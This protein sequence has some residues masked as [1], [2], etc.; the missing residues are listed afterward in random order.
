[1]TFRVN[2]Q[3]VCVDSKVGHEQ[4]IEIQEGEVYTVAWIGM[5]SHYVHGEY[6]GV[7]LAGIDRK[8]CPHFGYDN[9]PFA[10][11]RFRPLVRDRLASLRG[12]L[13]DGPITET[14]DEPKREVERKRVREEV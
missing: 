7:R 3:V 6:L 5:F 14:Y 8:T 10:A 13:N 12:L 11:S 9:P 2:E 4:Y 1:M